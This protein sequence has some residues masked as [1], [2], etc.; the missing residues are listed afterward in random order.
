MHACAAGRF[1]RIVH[2]SLPDVAAREQILQKYLL[3]VPVVPKPSISNNEKASVAGGDPSQGGTGDKPTAMMKSS[4]LAQPEE[5]ERSSLVERKS[6]P[7]SSSPSEKGSS[8]GE[9]TKKRQENDKKIAKKAGEASASSS[10][11][12]ESKKETK[13]QDEELSG[14]Q[15]R[16]ASSS[17]RERAGEDKEKDVKL[18]EETRDDSRQ[19]RLIREERETGEDGERKEEEKKE[20]TNKES[21][22][23]LT[24]VHRELAKKI[25]KI[26]PGFSGAELENLVNEAALLAARASTRYNSTDIHNIHTLLACVYRYLLCRDVASV[27]I[28]IDVYRHSCI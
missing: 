10:V 13:K 23:V 14:Q 26:T 15:Y 20:E 21:A 1:D 12:S 18:P 6:N 2:V 25:A 17:Q 9:L 7:E 24:P 27:S 8:Q 22:K 28:G 11:T 5:G 3:R 4:S 19:G 16:K